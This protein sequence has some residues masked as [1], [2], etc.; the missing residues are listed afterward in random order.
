MGVGGPAILCFRTP[1]LFPAENTISI[2]IKPFILGNS[3]SRERTHNF[4]S[5]TAII[6]ESISVKLQFIEYPVKSKTPMGSELV[7]ENLA[8]FKDT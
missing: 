3:R 7:G 6:P 5:M 4:R 2:T 8:L 1:F